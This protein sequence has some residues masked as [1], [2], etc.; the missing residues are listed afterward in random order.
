M[1]STLAVHF[2]TVIH[3]MTVFW[4][5]EGVWGGVESCS[6]ELGSGSRSRV[7]IGSIIFFD[8][9]WFNRYLLDVE[10]VAMFAIFLGDRSCQKGS[11]V[12]P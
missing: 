4:A 1:I 6:L 5:A 9:F 3:Q 10:D 7:W 2:W 11:C 12:L 8:L